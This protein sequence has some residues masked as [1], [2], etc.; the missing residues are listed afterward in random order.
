MLRTP[1]HTH[2]R[3]FKM[4][5]AGVKMFL[6]ENY[7]P[8]HLCGVMKGCDVVIW[9]YAQEPQRTTGK[10][11]ASTATNIQELQEAHLKSPQLMS[12]WSHS[13]LIK[14]TIFSV[15]IIILSASKRIKIRGQL[16]AG[17]GWR[18]QASGHTSYTSPW[19]AWP[20]G[21]TPWPTSS[22]NA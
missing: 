5:K 11:T 22:Q 6:V 21:A 19:A 17:H 10:G 9:G 2:N 16:W 8:P 14:V 15:A 3:T 4:F 1:T 12:Q 7:T 20:S 18:V 13:Y